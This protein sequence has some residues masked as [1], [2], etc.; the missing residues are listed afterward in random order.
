MLER[1][2]EQDERGRDREED[3]A[4][5]CAIDIHARRSKRVCVSVCVG[6]YGKSG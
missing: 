1:Q 5:A 2:E 4:T 3:I 6:A